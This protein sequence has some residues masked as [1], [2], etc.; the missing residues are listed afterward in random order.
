MKLRVRHELDEPHFFDYMNSSLE[1]NPSLKKHGFSFPSSDKDR[2]FESSYQHGEEGDCRDCDSSKEIERLP[3]QYLNEPQVH[4]GTIASGNQVLK[5]GCLRDE[6]SRVSREKCSQPILCYEMDAAGLWNH[7]PS[8]IIRGI[9]DYA[10]SHRNGEWQRYAALSAAAYAKELLVLLSDLESA[11]RS[12]TDDETVALPESAQLPISPA[13][14]ASSSGSTQLLT[15]SESALTNTVDPW[16]HRAVDDD[17]VDGEDCKCSCGTIFKG[18]GKNARSNRRR[19]IDSFSK[20]AL[21]A[22]DHAVFAC[23]YVS[24]RADN[25]ASHKRRCRFRPGSF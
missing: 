7:Y 25:V 1:K 11:K 3:R 19:H 10:D 22:F 20:G 8:L 16:E 6:I 17:D 9:C 18:R 5:N 4:Y 15:V 13:S 24:K 23:D 2:L 12:T 21:Y 14:E